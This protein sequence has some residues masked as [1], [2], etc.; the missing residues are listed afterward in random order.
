M[1][2]GE[3][4]LH[5]VEH[6]LAAAGL[7]LD[8]GM[9]R[10]RV[11]ADVPG[12]AS[13]L[14]LS[15][16]AFPVLEPEG[17]FDVTASLVLVSGV[18]RWVRPQVT[19]RLDGNEPFEPFPADTH[20]PMLEWGLNWAIANRANG[21]LLLHA[22]ALERD[23]RGVLLPALPGSGKSTLTAALST[24]GYR[25][26]SDEFGAVRLRE[27]ELVPAV[28]PI[29]LKNQSIEIMRRFAPSSTLG[30]EFP[31]TRKGRVA[32]L[33]PDAA[34]VE[35]RQ[36]CVQPALVVF[37]HYE[38]EASTTLAPMPK[39]RAF[40]KLAANSFNYE[41]LG[42]EGFEAMGR[43]IEQCTCFRLNYSQLDQAI[44]AI[45]QQLG[46]AAPTDK[47]IETSSISMH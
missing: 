15:Y 36:A 2:I 12:L 21:Y 45:S 34:S 1:R 4:E 8:F 26:L 32:Y 16:A 47:T 19:F 5:D 44:E 10:A 30:P 23:G 24:R 40:A 37:P 9:M 35:G 31:K 29:A 25:L 7:P 20:Q 22:G 6:R 33:A 18:R 39:S 41:I 28:R 13:T 17:F 46:L 3:L 38:P 42:P 11:R 43:L 14:R 27:G